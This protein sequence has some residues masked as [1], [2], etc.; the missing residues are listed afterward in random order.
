M[1][2]LEICAFFFFTLLLLVSHLSWHQTASNS[3]KQTLIQRWCEEGCRYFTKWRYMTKCSLRLTTAEEVSGFLYPHHSL[4]AHPLLLQTTLGKK[5]KKKEK[6]KG[7]LFWISSHQPP[8]ATLISTTM[9]IQDVMVCMLRSQGRERNIS[10]G[11]LWLK[12]GPLTGIVNTLIDNFIRYTLALL[13]RP[14]SDPSPSSRNL[15]E[16]L[17]QQGVRNVP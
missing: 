17:I 12:C 16:A 15:F 6:K 9:Q 10:A 4:P 3:A 7:E 1:P 5:K 8:R 2:V 11:G 14:L 13:C